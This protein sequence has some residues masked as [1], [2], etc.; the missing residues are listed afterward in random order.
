MFR[1]KRK[2]LTKEVEFPANLKELGYLI[3]END[4]IRHKDAPTEPF[5]YYVHGKSSKWST[6]SERM[7]LRHKEALDEC[8]RRIVLK[9]LAKLDLHPLTLPAG[10]APTE[11]HVPILASSK[12]ASAFKILLLLPD[13][14]RSSLG[15]WSIRKLVDDGVRVGSM[16]QV[17]EAALATGYDAIVALNPATLCWDVHSARALT[18]VSYAARD[19][20]LHETNKLKDLA[21]YTIPGHETPEAHIASV[22]DHLAATVRTDARIDFIAAEYSGFLLLQFLGA[23][24]ATWQHH[25]HAGVFIQSPHHTS[26]LPAG[27]FRHFV[28]ERCR[29]Y[30]P[31][32]E[33]A[34]GLRMLPDMS[35]ACPLYSG[36]NNWIELVLCHVVDEVMGYF[37]AA[38]DAGDAD[39]AWAKLNPDGMPDQFKAAMEGAADKAHPDAKFDQ[40][41]LVDL[42]KCDLA[43]ERPGWEVPGMEEIRRMAEEAEKARAVVEAERK[44][45]EEKRIAERYRRIREEEEKEVEMRELAEA[46]GEVRMHEDSLRRHG[47]AAA[48]VPAGAG[49]GDAAAAEKVR[50][51]KRDV[52]VQKALEADT[53]D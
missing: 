27:P 41:Q 6:N 44:E 33:T 35:R 4:V 11:R 8:C 15:I 2:P 12:L 30:V 14:Q 13:P 43:D 51:E 23:H 20:T 1:Q 19:R 49:A 48:D 9:R 29:N 42:S 40:A 46:V 3:D 17:V 47:T 38:W 37:A 50:P 18:P 16:Q 32:H 39:R 21:L 22:F 10:A 53:V 24:W 34:R 31:D 5:N 26:D 36:G 28:R 25:L 45:D 7:N 52:A